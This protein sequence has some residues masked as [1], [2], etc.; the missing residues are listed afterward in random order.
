LNGQEGLIPSAYVEL[1]TGSAAVPAVA[2]T[3]AKKSSAEKARALFDYD[4]QNADE[5]TIATGD[6]MEIKKKGEGT[7]TFCMKLIV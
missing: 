5:L 4:A 6:L 1:L 2:T 3:Q 7:A